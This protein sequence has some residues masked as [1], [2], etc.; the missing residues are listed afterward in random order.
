MRL[1]PFR[2][3]AHG[4]LTMATNAATVTSSYVLKRRILWL[5][6]GSQLPISEQRHIRSMIFASVPA[7]MTERALLRRHNGAWAKSLRQEF[8][9]TIQLNRAF[10]RLLMSG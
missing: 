9:C 4:F 6:G 5:R 1:T 8:H 3:T 10:T 2:R 7:R